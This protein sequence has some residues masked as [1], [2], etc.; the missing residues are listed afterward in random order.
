MKRAVQIAM[1]L[2]C[3]GAVLPRLHAQTPAQNNAPG[4][5]QSKPAPNAQK[6][7]ANA[8]KAG[9]PPTESNPFPDDTNSV[10]VVPT[11]LTPAAPPPE[12]TDYGNVRLPSGD[13]DPVRSPD[14]L[15]SAADSA[16]SGSSD[17]SQGID[18]LIEPPPDNGKHEK[19]R[20]EK[21]EEA[22][23]KDGPKEDIS[24]GSYYLGTK[25]WKGALSRFQSAFV[26]A[27]ENPEVYWG[28]AECQRHLG[29]DAEAKANYLK[30]MEYDP[31]SKH[32]KAAKKILEQPE[33]VNAPVAPAAE[34][35]K[36]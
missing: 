1:V 31:G 24:V 2:A 32:S 35:A 27:P 19:A 14:D 6:P 12:A 8:P 36:Q 3:C 23:P 13:N 9:S 4:S 18:Q 26:L 20:K 33:M 22:S 29:D 17:S 34:A 15:P 5:A 30:V 7:A 11:S 28:L 25:N 10:P 16:D 21:D